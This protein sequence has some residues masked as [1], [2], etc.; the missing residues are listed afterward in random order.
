MDDNSIIELYY[1]RDEQ[2]IDVTKKKYGRLVYSVAF[3]VVRSAEDSE[4]CEND[5]YYRAWQSIPPT[6]PSILSAVLCKIAR[7]L[8]I[9]RIRDEK[10]RPELFTSVIFEEICETIPDT[11][12]DITDDIELRDALNDFLASLGKTKRMIFVKRYFY[13][14]EI[15]EI[16]R[17]VDVT[18]GNVKTTLYR[19][20][21]E[22]RE[23][24][25]NRG[26]VL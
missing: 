9:N 4:E 21:K 20:R 14:R 5:T 8:A 6:R 2:A 25:E 23:F 17:E 11:D 3:N 7:N 13:M 16:A 24:L 22:L 10:R 12:G 1:N 18:F 19:L 26:I 15:N